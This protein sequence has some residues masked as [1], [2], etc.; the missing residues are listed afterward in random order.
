M[1]AWLAETWGFDSELQCETIPNL[2]STSKSNDSNT[3]PRIN[4]ALDLLKKY[5]PQ[6]YADVQQSKIEI[7]PQTGAYYWENV[8]GISLIDLDRYDLE[9]LAGVLVHEEYHN[10]LY[11]ELGS[12]SN[13]QAEELAC[14]D[15]Q[16]S[17]LKKIGAPWSDIRSLEQEDGLHYLRV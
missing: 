8:I 6:D 13:S 17:A 15:R 11:R 10:Q 2:E 3:H 4:E 12:K 5:S 14:I 16:I 7:R 9:W 1:F